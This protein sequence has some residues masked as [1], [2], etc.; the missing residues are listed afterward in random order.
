MNK[1]LPL[2]A[3][4]SAACT[5]NLNYYTKT[6]DTAVA[7]TGAEVALAAVPQ[8][9]IVRLALDPARTVFIT[10][11]IGENALL[12]A[13]NI[14]NLGASSEPI[15]IVLNS[16]GGS[17]M[18]GANIISAIEAARGP[19]NTVCNAMCASM[20]ALIFEYGTHRFLVDRT[21][22]MFHPASGGVEGELDK[23][24]S[25]TEAIQRFVAKL[26][27]H[28]AKRAGLTF[29]QYKSLASRELWL[30]AEDAVATGFADKLVAVTWPD[31]ATIT[32]PPQPV[33]PG[34]TTTKRNWE[35]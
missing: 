32:P 14:S 10:G 12:I 18:H 24:A 25:R 22:L 30:D 27:A 11:E 33:I 15:T 3:L 4:A 29:G 26:E 6:V 7:P 5:P 21:I 35:F 13:A 31:G 28:V 8:K 9:R 2:I 19:V 1:Y 34:N 23:M 17:V 20:A 16:P